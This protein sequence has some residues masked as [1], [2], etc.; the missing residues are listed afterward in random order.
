MKITL[1]PAWILLI[2]AAAVAPPLCADDVKSYDCHKI[3]HPLNIN[4][5]MDDAAWLSAPWTDDFID[6][7]GTAKPKP[8]FQTRVK[9]LWDDQYF[10]IAA[11]LEEPHVWATL[12][13][14]DSI[15][16]HDND[17]EVFMDPAGTGLNYYEFEINAL[18]TSWDLILDKPYRLGGKA[19]NNW[20][21]PGL[22]TAIHVDGSLNDAADTDKG[23]TVEIAF[24]WKALAQY[25]TKPSPPQAGD[26]WRLNLSRVEWQD[27]I[28]GGKYQIVPK[29]KE[30][31]WVWSP[32]GEINMHIPE[33]W[34]KVRFL[35]Q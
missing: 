13:K 21:I 2:T 15:I 24:P 5:K 18:N 20:D 11:T 23:W 28:V 33:R 17:F 26:I 7:E 8:R 1:L 35:A 3:D 34:G 10:Y 9:M 22:K 4:G 31:N 27:N 14:H 29:S 12:T 19:N 16:F 25:A 32:Q 30:D 6:I